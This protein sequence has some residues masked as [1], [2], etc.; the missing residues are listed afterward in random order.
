[1]SGATKLKVASL[2]WDEDGWPV[3]VYSRSRGINDSKAYSKIGSRVVQ[4]QYCHTNNLYLICP[5]VKYC[6]AIL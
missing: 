4:I 2:E 3:A 5:P 6:K 1:M